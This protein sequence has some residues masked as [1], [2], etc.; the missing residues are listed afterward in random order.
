MPS[1]NPGAKDTFFVR[2]TEILDP[3]R[4]KATLEAESRDVWGQK[5]LQLPK[6]IH[7]GKAAFK[8]PFQL[9]MLNSNYGLASNQG[10][11]RIPERIHRGRRPNF[12]ENFNADFFTAGLM[13]EGQIKHV[14]MSDALF[15]E[16]LPDVQSEY[17]SAINDK[18]YHEVPSALITGFFNAILKFGVHTPLQMVEAL[19]HLI[20]LPT[21]LVSWTRDQAKKSENKIGWGF[22]T[23]IAAILTLPFQC[24][25]IFANTINY[26][27]HVVDGMV[28]GVK[29]L[30]NL[31]VDL[32]SNLI[33]GKGDYKACF[34]KAGSQ[35]KYAAKA[36]GI[37]LLKLLPVALTLALAYAT[38]GLSLIASAPI[39]VIG[40]GPLMV[41]GSQFL[42]L[43]L[44]GI[45][46]KLLP[47]ASSVKKT[48]QHKPAEARRAF[49]AR[50]VELEAP[51]KRPLI[52]PEVTPAVVPQTTLTPQASEPVN[53]M[54]GEMPPHVSDATVIRT[55]LNHPH[56][57]TPQKQ[58]QLNEP[59]EQV[60][61]NESHE[62]QHQHFFHEVIVPHQTGN[63]IKDPQKEEKGESE[64][65]RDGDRDGDNKDAHL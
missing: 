19:C 50:D 12:E 47:E 61:I 29:A 38:G 43:G 10:T 24:F 5:G 6:G 17:L 28:T 53:E 54:P 27:R 48:Y 45:K 15:G 37:H 2:T 13:V 46:R 9:A 58:A 56:E 11:K 41:A 30:I 16:S 31:P 3:N 59:Q 51:E 52:T 22:L 42:S 8:P 40:I 26:V 55:L 34:D 57:F 33:S 35:I 60:H 4:S 63:K 65:D 64:E 14:A 32:L 1:K 39:A 20:S 21:Q 49:K 44:I 62:S 23:A 18:K 25:S 7:T 36:V